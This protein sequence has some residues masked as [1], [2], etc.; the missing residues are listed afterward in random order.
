M[1]LFSLAALTDEADAQV[2][3]SIALF[4]G[5]GVDRNQQLAAAYFRKAALAGNPIAQDRLATILASG[6]GVKANPVEAARWRIISKAAGETNLALDE[7]VNKLDPKTRAQA[8]NEAR[9][10]VEFIKRTLA[11]NE[12][13]AAAAPPK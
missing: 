5:D 8:E 11:A 12:R 6:L 4:N 3:Y 10:W 9:P 13:A 2:E 1:R 7:F